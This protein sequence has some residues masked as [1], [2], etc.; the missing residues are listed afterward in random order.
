MAKKEI[1]FRQI[2]QNIIVVINGTQYSRR[3]V[4]KTEREDIKKDVEIYNTKNSAK[5]EKS[6]IDFMTVNTKERNQKLKEAKSSTKKAVSKPEVASKKVD[7]E[8]KAK[9]LKESKKAKVN[10]PKASSYSR[11]GEW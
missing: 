10:E 7:R 2:G 4:E 1:S 3:V 5:L 6:I 11:S 8:V 9:A